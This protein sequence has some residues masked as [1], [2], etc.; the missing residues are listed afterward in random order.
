MG[1]YKTPSDRFIEKSNQ[2]QMADLLPSAVDDALARSE[3]LAEAQGSKSL[4]VNDF[5]ANRNLTTIMSAPFVSYS[6]IL[7]FASN[8]N[9]S[10]NSSCDFYISG[11]QLYSNLALRMS[12][13]S[14]GLNGYIQ[15]GWGLLAIKFIQ[16][17]LNN[18]GLSP[19]QITG[20]SVF[21]YIMACAP[22]Q[23]FRT[24]M[25][26]I[27]GPPVYGAGKV[28]EACVPLACFLGDFVAG[29]SFPIDMA[30]INS[31]RIT[32]TFNDAHS[33]CTRYS[34]GG[35]GSPSVLPTQLNTLELV[36]AQITLTDSRFTAS[37]L[38]QGTGIPYSLPSKYITS[39]VVNIP[40]YDF[41][42]TKSIFLNDAPDGHLTAITLNLTPDFWVYNTGGYAKIPFGCVLTNCRL[43]YNGVDLVRW[44]S[45]EEYR[46][47]IS[48]KFG[49]DDLKI[50]YSYTRNGGAVASGDSTTLSD[51]L[52]HSCRTVND[53]FLWVLPMS[54]HC[55]KI[56]S[57]HHNENQA[58]YSGKS[59]QL[60]FTAKPSFNTD[61]LKVRQVNVPP[62]I[63]WTTLE[64]DFEDG[65]FEA[66]DGVNDFFYWSSVGSANAILNITYICEATL[67]ARNTFVE[68]AK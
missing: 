49:G 55:R 31:I 17:T 25:L 16:I 37:T 18:S 39:S 23:E 35:N 42:T 7:R 26:D 21:D 54:H 60:T 62:Q 10:L 13:N 43:S 52:N 45:L 51:G 5:Y 53:A 50:D 19:Q 65:F 33:F 32:I 28:S 4:N 27:C 1:K 30:M 12:V 20:R 24:N 6:N 44:D 36:G 38:L 9:K 11:S 68:M 63:P 3:F 57:D 22:S 58:N 14:P 34:T 64:K 66:Y 8:G 2:I 41:N 56:F 15:R 67:L 59:L 29:S 48:Q 46:Y 61:I 47:M 40:G